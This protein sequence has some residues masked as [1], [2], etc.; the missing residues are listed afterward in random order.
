MSMKPNET[1]LRPVLFWDVDFSG[2]DFAQHASYI[3]P[4]VMDRGN[5][6]EVKFIIGYYG[7]ETI[8]TVLIEARS[9]QNDTISFFSLYFNL[10]RETF[11]AYRKKKHAAWNR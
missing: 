10:P 3:I 11:L 1:L 9:L 5:L 4:R 7:I 8:K 2:M 6:E